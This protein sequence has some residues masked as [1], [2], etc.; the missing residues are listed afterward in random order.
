ML[1]VCGCGY[2]AS[3]PFKCV[4]VGSMHGHTCSVHPQSSLSVFIM[5][6]YSCSV[7]TALRCGCSIMKPTFYL[8]QTTSWLYIVWHYTWRELA[9]AQIHEDEVKLHTRIGT[10]LLFA[11][12]TYVTLVAAFLRAVSVALIHGTVAGLRGPWVL[13][14]TSWYWTR[15]DAGNNHCTYSYSLLL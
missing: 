7:F 9:T 11:H 12:T 4:S 13:T 5:L 8:H 2:S 15:K 1:S 3:Q 6:R 10:S 14:V